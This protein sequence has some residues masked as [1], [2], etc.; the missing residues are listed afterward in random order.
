MKT[1]VVGDVSSLPDHAFGLKSLVWWGLLGWM[2]IEAMAFLLACAV[3]LYVRGLNPTWP[4]PPTPLPG[5]I[6]G[7]VTTVLFVVSEVANRWTAR[8][9]KEMDDG[10][11]KLGVVLVILLALLVT[12][13]RFFEFP[14]LHTRWDADAYGSVVWLLMVMHTA[15]L[16]TDLADTLVLGGWLFTHEIEPTQHTEVYDNCGYWTF[17]VVSWLPTWFLVYIAP[18]LL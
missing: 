15:H 9:A 10:K 6:P 8:K 17:V 11:V 7:I 2:T 4:M 3:W 14:Q 16:L 5:L 1:T 12:I 13:S 18:R